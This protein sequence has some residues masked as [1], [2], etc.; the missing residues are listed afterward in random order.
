VASERTGMADPLREVSVDRR[1]PRLRLLALRV[2]PNRERASAL[3]SRRV[4]GRGARFGVAAPRAASSRVGQVGQI[5]RKSAYLP[6]RVPRLRGVASGSSRRCGFGPLSSA[7]LL[8]LQLSFGNAAIELGDGQAPP[9]SDANTDGRMKVWFSKP[10]GRRLHETR[11]A[12][13]RRRKPSRS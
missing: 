10:H 13:R 5:P 8:T 3:H 1:T 7:D 9:S 12:S 11:Q 2:E 6:V 4:S